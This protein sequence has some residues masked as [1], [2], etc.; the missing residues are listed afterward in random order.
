MVIHVR[1]NRVIIVQTIFTKHVQY[2]LLADNTVGSIGT[3]INS[4]QY[5]VIQDRLSGCTE[6]LVFLSPNKL[7]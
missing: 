4:V 3:V 5:V 6:V 1:V 2:L 7:S